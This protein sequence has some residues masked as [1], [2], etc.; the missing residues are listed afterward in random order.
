MEGFRVESRVDNCSL[1][2][3]KPIGN[4]P[5][6]NPITFIK[7]FSYI[8]QLFAGQK[9]SLE[10][11]YKP[12]RFS[13]NKP[14]GRCSRCRGMG[15]RRVEMHFMADLFVPCEEC[16]G[17]RYNSET[18]DIRYKG[19]DISEVL[20]LTVSEAKLFFDRAPKLG[21]K[22]WM[23]SE[24]GLGYLRLGQ[25]SNTLSGGEAQR[26]K[27]AREL[28]ESGGQ[29][30]L[31]IMDEPT[32]GLHM[33][34]IDNLLRIF[35]KLVDSGHSLVVIEHNLDVIGSADWVIDLG[36]GG[37]ESGGEVVAAGPPKQIMAAASSI[38]GRYLKEYFKGG[39]K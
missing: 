31:Y 18:L 34:D 11:G 16:G 1:V 38:T 26:I 5:R 24:V 13:F 20:E 8:R 39:S 23:L 3:Q 4:T 2:D 9:K 30:N 28:S 15:Y 19:R 29:K 25:P 27:I 21:E 12:G 36:P 35:Q 22:L 14:E 33:S 6:S 10:R 32:T 7:G 37:G 17:K